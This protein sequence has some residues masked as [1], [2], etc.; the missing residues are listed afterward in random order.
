[1]L[2]LSVMN[3]ATVS[4]LAA[5]DFSE[6]LATDVSEALVVLEQEQCG[7]GEAPAECHATLERLLTGVRWLIPAD[8]AC[9]YLLRGGTLRLIIAQN[10]TLSARLGEAEFRRRLLGQVLAVNSRSIAGYVALTGGPV[11][12]PDMESIPADGPYTFCPAIDRTAYCYRSLLTAPI[13]DEAGAIVGVVQLVNALDDGVRPVPFG[14]GAKTIVREFC[15]KA[16]RVIG[17]M[18]SRKRIS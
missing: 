16:A 3:P 18:T 2:I 17:G 7:R 4:A 1:L 6:D 11:S 8:G 10:D 14:P 12:I 9:L 5:K 15:V 13:F